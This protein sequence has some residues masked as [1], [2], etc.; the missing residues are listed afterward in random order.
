[1]IRK[2]I[3]CGIIGALSVG[4]H[5]SA[6]NCD[7]TG[8]GSQAAVAPDRIG[9]PRELAANDDSATS[10]GRSLTPDATPRSMMPWVAT[11]GGL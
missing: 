10:D 9:E 8:A 2:P 3:G 11:P 6:T 7:P 5:R 1:L 4:Q